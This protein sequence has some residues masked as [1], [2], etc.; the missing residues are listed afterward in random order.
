MARAM[1]STRAYKADSAGT[2]EAFSWRTKRVTRLCGQ[3]GKSLGPS[4]LALEVLRERQTGGRRDA[5]GLESSRAV[6]DDK[7]ECL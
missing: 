3:D 7:E 5:T 6:K 1:D 2:R 4:E